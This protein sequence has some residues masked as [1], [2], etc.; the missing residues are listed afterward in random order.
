MRLSEK[1]FLNRVASPPAQLLLK[2]GSMKLLKLYSYAFFNTFF[3]YIPYLAL[4]LSVNKGL[5][6]NQFALLVSVFSFSVFIFEIP[7]GFIADKIGEKKSIVIG[8]LIRLFGIVF[9]T[10]S[11]TFLFLLI[12]EALLGI[13][14]TFC[15]G[16]D[17]SLMYKIV[18]DDK[19]LKSKYNKIVS[20]Y[21]TLN[22]ISI[23]LAFLLGQL[24]ASIS[25]Q[26]VFIASII[27]TAIGLF[28]SLQLP[29]VPFVPEQKKSIIIIRH[30]LTDIFS[31]KR[32]LEIFLLTSLILAALS[33]S[34]LLFQPYLNEIQL[35]GKNNGILFFA[36]TLFAILGSMIQPFIVKKSK[37]NL[38][39]LLLVLLAITL[40]AIGIL[41]GFLVLLLFCIFR[42]IWGITTPL[43]TAEMNRMILYD[44]SRSTIL[45]I[46]SLFSNLL[47]GL[48]L[49][50]V[51]STGGF[52]ATKIIIIGLLILIVA[53]GFVCLSLLKKN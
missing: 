25:Y 14:S 22:W 20:N 36:I 6:E 9:L 33:S 17:D 52:V 49:F 40:I 30:A 21:Y 11:N 45:S 13:G 3:I 41:K 12:G 46:R 8:N 28:I 43:V 24:L 1:S 35:S 31:N 37:N 38:T 4:F 48:L 29:T 15:S 10:F 26:V 19:D 47:Q 23:S 44:N 51:A 7:T 18:H 39:V 50:T 53:G 16:A 42:F 5:T 32:L 2:W 34:Y 27:A